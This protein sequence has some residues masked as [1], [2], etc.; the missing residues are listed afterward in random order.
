MKTV[1]GLFVYVA[2]L[3]WPRCNFR[4]PSEPYTIPSLDKILPYQARTFPGLHNARFVSVQGHAGAL[5]G[6]SIYPNAS[7]PTGEGEVMER[8]DGGMVAKA[9]AVLYFHGNGCNRAGF[10][11]VRKYKL[12]TSMGFHV[13]AFDY[14]GF[15]DSE[16]WPDEE[17]LVEDAE[18]MFQFVQDEGFHANETMFWGHSLGGAVA[19]QLASR[20]S[21]H[22]WRQQNK[23][24]RQGSRSSNKGKRKGGRR[25]TKEEAVAE[26]KAAR[27]P[28]SS[29]AMRRPHSIVLESTFTS[30][31]EL[32]WEEYTP[33]PL[34][35]FLSPTA[36]EQLLKH[37]FPSIIEIHSTHSPMLIL[38][39]EDDRV[40]PHT[41]GA[42]LAKAAASTRE[43]SD[44]SSTGS[45]TCEASVAVEDS[46]PTTRDPSGAQQL[47]YGDPRACSPE[48]NYVRFLK[49][50]GAG[51]NTV[52][53]KALDT[54]RSAVRILSEQ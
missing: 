1:Q 31:S 26:A 48:H 20:L 40:I 33:S 30:I 12:L 51:H 7:Q 35:M 41:H 42:A 4:R 50:E 2:I 47:E 9:K 10:D 27:E 19:V 49:V 17:G 22:R 13:F 52:V 23:S 3:N 36:L 44:A 53:E 34:A 38:H 15:G 29:P 11:H 6:W 18:S 37:H 39:G 24:K 14:R 43:V 21:T 32:I 8:S 16:G 5:N 45:D 54:V 25:K 28:N 46:S